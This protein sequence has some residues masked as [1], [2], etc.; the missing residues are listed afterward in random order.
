[1]N[2]NLL[3]DLRD[4]KQLNIR[5]LLLLI[6]QLSMPTILAQISTIVMQYIDAAMV[7]HLGS[8]ESASIG[9]MAS[10][11][12]L[13]GSVCSAVSVGFTIQIAHSIGAKDSKNARKLVKEGLCI[14]LLT[15]F[16][17]ASV[18]LFIH[19]G[20][21]GWLGGEEAILEDASKYFLVYAMS[22][23]ALQMNTMAT[24]MLQCSGN[25]KI[26]S[27]LE[28]V[29]CGLDVIF[30]GVL[31]FPTTSRVIPVLNLK[32]TIPGAGLGVMGAALGTALAQAVIALC[33][34]YF[35]LFRSEELA[36]FG[37][38]ARKR[39]TDASNQ[40]NQKSEN[41][42]SEIQEI[43][44]DLSEDY[45]W[46]KNHLW[47]ALRMA[48]PVA[49]EQTILCGAY[50]VSTKIVAPLGMIAMAAHSFS[51]TAES[52]C[53]MPG[54]GIG[55]AATTIIGQ[56]IGAGRKDLTKK[57]AWMCTGFG[58]LLMTG[59]GLMMYILAPWMIGVLSPDQAIRS[60]GTKVLRIEVLAEPF[61]AASIVASGA[62]RGAGDTLAP[63]CMNF[64]SM[65]LVR[66]PLSAIL[67]KS[68]G[69]VG[70]WIAM[71]TELCFRGVI[72]LF[73][74]ATKKWHLVKA[75]HE[76]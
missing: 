22:L 65:W 33:M 71:C 50:I 51:V 3:K 64:I 47:N 28:T 14:G 29:M 60:L 61:Y 23:P 11:T 1:M 8:G 10:S 39:V 43:Q 45:F 42:K 38:V 73:R 16:L 36:I 18:A 67:A 7:G 58:M 25:M 35:M 21:P 44:E 68:H 70:V 9:L 76:R 40:K 34:L 24:G 75:Q 5:Q 56:S 72:F 2:H 37:K 62:L 19:K 15:G 26:P 74:L 63:S 55:S 66:L 57:L 4:G 48:T 32:V 27:I 49:F 69:L 30:N 20:L 12:W 41:N 53:Y 59:T 52:L 6:I 17:M 54:Y 46:N 13:L 31:I